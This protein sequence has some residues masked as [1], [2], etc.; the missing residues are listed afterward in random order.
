MNLL[1]SNGAMYTPGT[2]LAF[3]FLA[4]PAVPLFLVLRMSIATFRE[5]NF[6]VGAAEVGFL[7]LT[8]V[9][10]LWTVWESKK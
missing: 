10:L 5:G 2:R 8:A 9:A 7:L 4:V 3:F 1:S 6:L